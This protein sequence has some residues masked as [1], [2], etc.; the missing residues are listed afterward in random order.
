MAIAHA[1]VTVT[2]SPTVLAPV[3]PNADRCVVIQNLGTVSV[4]LGSP[5]V[6]TSSYG[7]ELKANSSLSF[8]VDQN[9]DL[10]GVVASGTQVVNVLAG[11]A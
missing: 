7:Y 3:Y 1:R 2:T 6:T 4:Y 11:R 5:S 9:E 8:D 10:Y